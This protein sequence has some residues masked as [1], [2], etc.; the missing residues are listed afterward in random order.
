MKIEKQNNK[1]ALQGI[2]NGITLKKALPYVAGAVVIAVA[3]GFAVKKIGDN[4]PELINWDFNNANNGTTEHPEILGS[5]GIDCS[6]SYGYFHGIEMKFNMKLKANTNWIDFKFDIGRTEHRVIS[7]FDGQKWI[8]QED[9]KSDD[10]HNTDEF[11]IPTTNKPYV[12]SY[13]EPGFSF[14]HI[15][16]ISKLYPNAT[17][18]LFKVNYEEFLQ[19]KKSWWNSKKYSEN[20]IKWHAIVSLAKNNNQWQMQGENEIELGH[21]KNL[22]PIN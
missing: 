12:I 4:F 2:S 16:N 9:N 22:Y 11:L 15:N 20:K 6:P 18:L 19:V 1:Q 13:D 17:K 14:Q 7:I 5:T 21:L 3:T 10:K 8:S